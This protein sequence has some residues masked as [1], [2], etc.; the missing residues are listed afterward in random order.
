M[1]IIL[2]RKGFDSSAGGKPSPIYKNKFISIPIPE[3]ESGIRYSELTFDEEYD[4]LKVMKDLHINYFTEAHLDPD[5]RRSAYKERHPDWR[6]IFGQDGNAQKHLE[7][8]NIGNRENIDDNILFFFW[9]WFR[10][11]TNENGTFEYVKNAPNIHA[12]WG[13]MEVGEIIKLNTK[14]DKIQEWMKYHPHI[15]FN[16]KN[17]YANKNTIYIA[18]DKLGAGVFKYHKDLVLTEENETRRSIWELPA[19][20]NG[21]KIT[22]LDPIP[23][24]KKI[25]LQS[26]GRGQEFIVIEDPNK[27]V[28]NWA[29]NLI[30]ECP[31]YAKWPHD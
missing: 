19:C 23:N 28:E 27:K 15:I 12:I 9:G 7:N 30:N 10:K 31:T 11:V 2:S 18:S 29:K 8:N 22:H 20:F 24:S 25:T 3:A 1:R 26:P 5:L 13:Y 6:P 21:C 16:G 17:E 14:E 4:Y